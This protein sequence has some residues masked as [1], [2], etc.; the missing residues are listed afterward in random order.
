MVPIET[1][2]AHKENYGVSRP[3][4]SIEYIVIHYTG[5]DG[6]SAH[7]NGLYFKNN[8]LKTSAHYFVDSDMITQSV[9]DD[10]VA[11]HCGANYYKHKE[12]RNYNSIGIEI[13]DEVK[14]GVIYPTA[15]TIQNTLALT[16]S[17]M[18]KYCIPADHIIR[19]YDVTGKNCPAYWVDDT[20]W[21]KEFWNKL[22]G[23]GD[24][25]LTREDVIAIIQEY[26]A[27]KD[28]YP[29]SDWANEAWKAAKEK[30]IMDGT[31]PKSNAT[32][33]QIATILHRLGLL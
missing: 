28:L 7:N 6:G 11:Y 5:T 20:K 25:V 14:N 26:E 31:R 21:K 32:R 2:L 19:H 24:E 9:P 17:L 4:S 15:K 27:T 33:E 12:C 10:Y 13:C 30:G 16:R 22:N 3:A 18:D 8:A 1:V 29:V 23:Q